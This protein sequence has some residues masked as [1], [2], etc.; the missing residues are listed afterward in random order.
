MKGK[1]LDGAWFYRDRNHYSTRGAAVRNNGKGWF[2]IVGSRIRGPL[3]NLESAMNAADKM[4]DEVAKTSP[5]R[6]AVA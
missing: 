1:P 5:D 2:A 6:E 4:L 3:S